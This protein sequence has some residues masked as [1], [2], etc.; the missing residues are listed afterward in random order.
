MASANDSSKRRRLLGDASP[1]ASCLLSDLPNGILTHVANY[2][3]APSRLF[4]AAALA[5][6]NTAA[7]DERNSVIVDNEWTTLD[8]GDI[9]EDLAVKLINGDIS[10]VLLCID[11]VNRLKRLKLTNCINITGVGLEPL[12]GSTIIEQIDLSL[13]GDHQSP[14]ISPKPPISCEFVLP[15]LDSIIER[16]GCSL[17]HVQF[18]S[19]WSEG[20]KS[21]Q[22][23]QFRIR[24]NEML[25]NRGVGCAK[26]NT[27]LP[28]GDLSWI[29][30][31]IVQNFT[32]YECLKHFCITC[33]NDDG[34]DVLG[35]CHN[36]KK[37]YCTDCQKSKGCICCDFEYCVDC[38]D[39]T[40][41]SGCDSVFC[42]EC[43]ASGNEHSKCYECE[44]RFCNDFCAKY[45]I[46]THCDSCKKSCCNN[47]QEDY[48]QEDW[49]SCKRCRDC[50]CDDCN[51]K[52][53][54]LYAIQ[55]CDSCYTSYCGDCREFVTFEGDDIMCEED[56]ENKNCAGCVQ[57]AGLISDEKWRLRN[58]SSFELSK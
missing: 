25:D 23:E 26:C 11:A 45:E 54:I 53:G 24:Y 13:V 44:G 2:L 6:Q 37:G 39:F 58:G 55:M 49:P 8:F 46:S 57:L 15:I 22:F 14:N 12:R 48:H 40:D 16:E 47:C 50:F 9:E 42:E 20:G 43:I 51:E 41:C 17:R 35:H 19:V 7:S 28:P 1:D 27:N 29:G 31:R 30:E 10:A 36:C 5:N 4:F 18:P 21:I 52:K 33:T 34:E 3:D 38:R 56:E 32:C